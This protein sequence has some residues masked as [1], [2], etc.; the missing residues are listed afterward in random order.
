M[1]KYVG[2]GWWVVNASHCGKGQRGIL[3]SFC[4]SLSLLLWKVVVQIFLKHLV[5]IP[6]RGLGLAVNTA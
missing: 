2:K 6:V 5:Q 1:G 4:I 3:R